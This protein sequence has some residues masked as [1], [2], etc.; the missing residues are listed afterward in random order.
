MENSTPISYAI[1]IEI[2]LKR[3]LNGLLDHLIEAI[4]LNSQIELNFELKLE[5]EKAMLI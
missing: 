1:W 3:Q 4:S 2:P 5:R